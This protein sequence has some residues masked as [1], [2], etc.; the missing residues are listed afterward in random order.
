MAKDVFPN[1]QSASWPTILFA[2]IHAHYQHLLSPTCKNSS[3]ST[4][5]SIAILLALIVL[6]ELVSN[7][8]NVLQGS[9]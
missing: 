3:I 5:A 7:A 2:M 8:L 1:A 6:M 9:C 4:D